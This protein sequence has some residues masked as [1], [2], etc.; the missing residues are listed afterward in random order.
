LPKSS[1]NN[2]PKLIAN[3]EH[4]APMVETERSV[5]PGFDLKCRIVATPASTAP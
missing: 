3:A 5:V 4:A 1:P 2:T